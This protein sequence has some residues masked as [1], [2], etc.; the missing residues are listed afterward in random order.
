VTMQRRVAPVLERAAAN[1]GGRRSL[2]PR[3]S[4]ALEIPPHSFRVF[5]SEGGPS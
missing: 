3:R 1:L 5:R 4:F 2:A